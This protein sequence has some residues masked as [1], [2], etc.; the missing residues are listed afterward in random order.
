MRFTN[1]I[2]LAKFVVAS[3]KLRTYTFPLLAIPSYRWSDREDCHDMK[4]YGLSGS[5][6]EK[7]ARWKVIEKMCLT[8]A[9]KT[10]WRNTNLATWHKCKSS[11]H[12]KSNYNLQLDFTT[13]D[14]G[15]IQSFERRSCRG[16]WHPVRVWERE[17]PGFQVLMLMF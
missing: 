5:K 15:E 8:E 1:L 6:D 12:G 7:A 14:T 16:V 17:H 11:Y 4:H 10:A 2:V 3:R 13:V 9:G